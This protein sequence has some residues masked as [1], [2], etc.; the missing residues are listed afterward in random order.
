MLSLILVALMIVTLLSAVFIRRTESHKSNQLLLML[1]MSGEQSLDYYFD[2]VQNSVLRVADF[3][4]EDL[5]GL[6]D[7]QFAQHMPESISV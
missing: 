1:C 3:V 4:E 6:E 2:S 5:D 7:E